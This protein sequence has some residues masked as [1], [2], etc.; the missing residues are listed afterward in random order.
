MKPH[1][2]ASWLQYVIGSTAYMGMLT[3]PGKPAGKESSI[4]RLDKVRLILPQGALA[5]VIDVILAARV[6][7]LIE[8]NLPTPSCCFIGGRPRTQPMD[9]AHTLQCCIEKSL[10]LRSQGA[11]AQGDIQ[12]F[13]DSLPMLKIFEWLIQADA[14]D[15][16]AAA[17]MRHQLVGT[18]FICLPAAIV[19]AAVH[20]RCVGGLTGSRVAGAG[21]R[22]P[23]EQTIADRCRHWAKWSFA[24]RI[25]MS[26]YIDNLYSASNSAHGAVSIIQDA[27]EYLQDNW[28]LKIKPDSKIVMPVFGHDPGHWRHSGK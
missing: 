16:L 5:E 7:T 17:V 27:E 3:T 24:G 20:S 26:V 15:A 14:G 21:G 28:D 23:V 13:Y 11:I 1:L 6:H 4:T 12:Q 19:T 8:R 18:V 2:F 9:I 22:I 10:D 25:T